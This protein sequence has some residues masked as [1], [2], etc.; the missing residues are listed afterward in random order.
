MLNKTETA[1]LHSIVKESLRKSDLS[2]WHLS[3]LCGMTEQF[4]AAVLGIQILAGFKNRASLPTRC[5]AF[6]RSKKV[7]QSCFIALHFSCSCQGQIMSIKVYLLAL[8]VAF[9]WPGWGGSDQQVHHIRYKRWPHP[10]VGHRQGFDGFPLTVPL[11]KTQGSN[12]ASALTFTVVSCPQAHLF[13]SGRG[14]GIE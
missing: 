3:W 1:L 5:K 4:W 10:T 7:M 8:E 6:I 13:Q 2:V 14:A 12:C 9:T 11:P